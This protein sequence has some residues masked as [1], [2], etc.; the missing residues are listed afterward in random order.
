M[1]KYSVFYNLIKTIAQRLIQQKH[2][3]KQVS[4]FMNAK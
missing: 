1:L 4:D 3:I 2:K